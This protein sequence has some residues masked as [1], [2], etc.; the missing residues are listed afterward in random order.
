MKQ[1]WKNLTNSHG[2]ADFT[3]TSPQTL[4]LSLVVAEIMKAQ[5][6]MEAIQSTSK[7]TE[8]SRV[9]IIVLVIYSYIK[10]HPK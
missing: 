7:K 3:S 9:W 10:N 6:G 4:D 5:K 2:T 8:M 1:E